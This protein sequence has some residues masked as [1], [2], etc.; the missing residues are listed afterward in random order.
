MSGASGGTFRVL[1][2][3]HWCKSEN[4]GS[5]PSR[6]TT[7]PTLRGLPKEGC[8]QSM[9]SNYFALPGEFYTYSLI[10]LLVLVISVLVVWP[11]VWSKDPARRLAAFEVLDR[12]LTFFRSPRAGIADPRATVRK[13]LPRARRRQRAHQRLRGKRAHQRLRGK[14]AHQRLRG[15]S[16]HRRP[17]HRATRGTGPG[18][19]RARWLH[20][21]TN[22]E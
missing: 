3:Q 20:Q 12:I 9:E 4:E 5:A 14:R 21:P 15:R 8:Y 11:A 19:T 2:I 1:A 13:R 7:E 18:E 16:H 22:A 10:I 6:Q 17:L